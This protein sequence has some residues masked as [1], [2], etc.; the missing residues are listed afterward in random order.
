MRSLILTAAALLSSVLVTTPAAKADDS[1]KAVTVTGCLTQGDEAKEFAIKDDTGK[2]YGLFSAHV[3]L[4]N[5]L[6]HTVTIT[7]VPAKEHESGE[8]S[9]VKAGKAEESEHL[10]VT[11]LKMVSTSCK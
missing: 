5:H 6:G 4:K 9:P 11:N 7:G 1:K 8:K 3:A 2:T 10:N